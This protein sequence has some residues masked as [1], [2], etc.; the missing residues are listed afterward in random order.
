MRDNY[1]TYVFLIN[2]CKIQLLVS[3]QILYYNWWH[4]VEF[5]WKFINGKNIQIASCEV[6]VFRCAPIIE[7]FRV[8]F[9][10]FITTVK[11]NVLTGNSGVSYR[12]LLL[13]GEEITYWLPWPSQFWHCNVSPLL[14]H[15]RSTG[16]FLKENKSLDIYI[17]IL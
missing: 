16:K 5:Q 15:A 3:K 7:T 9:S 4:S 2:K 17:C 13:F 6:I 11:Y 8:L 14:P 12:L 1:R 10:L